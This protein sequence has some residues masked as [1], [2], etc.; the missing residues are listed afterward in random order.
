M[1]LSRLM[2]SAVCWSVRLKTSCPVMRR[3]ISS[4]TVSPNCAA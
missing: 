2:L 1:R 4:D 3:R